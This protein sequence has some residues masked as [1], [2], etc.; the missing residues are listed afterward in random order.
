[1][2]VV[3]DAFVDEAGDACHGVGKFGVEYDGLSVEGCAYECFYD[4]D[5]CGF[6]SEFY[7]GVSFVCGYDDVDFKGEFL[8]LEWLFDCHILFLLLLIYLN[9]LKE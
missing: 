4:V 9:V 7:A 1:M 2:V 3:Y 5:V 8:A 6:S